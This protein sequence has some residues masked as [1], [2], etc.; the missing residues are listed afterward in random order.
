MIAPV[1][2]AVVCVVVGAL[3][4]SGLVKVTLDHCGG[5]GRMF[6]DL[7]GCEVGHRRSLCTRWRE[8]GGKREA[9]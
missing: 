6:A 5:G 4:C 1:A 2:E 3:V 9:W 8:R 7:C